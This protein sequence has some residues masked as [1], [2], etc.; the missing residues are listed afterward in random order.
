MT[1]AMA[2]CQSLTIIDNNLSGDPIDLKMFEFTGWNLTESN[3]LWQTSVAPPGSRMA[4][5]ETPSSD[6]IGIV[7]QFQFS[8]DL[9][10]MSVIVK[11]LSVKNFTVFCKGSPEKMERISD[12]A[13]IPSDFH[14][15]LN[16]YDRNSNVVVY[17]RF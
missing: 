2:T 14:A 1:K 12:P 10:C 4:D 11:D 13:T 15:I 7:K 3:G 6:E 8:S 5:S 17:F 9:Q 16:T